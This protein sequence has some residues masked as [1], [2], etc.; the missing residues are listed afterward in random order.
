MQ[1]I[2]AGSSRR[3]K[4]E[5]KGKLQEDIMFDKNNTYSLLFFPFEPLLYRYSSWRYFRAQ[6]A[7]QGTNPSLRIILS[8]RQRAISAFHETIFTTTHPLL[9]HPTAFIAM[10]TLP[11]RLHP[12][13]S[14]IPD[15]YHGYGRNSPLS[16]SSNSNNSNNSRTRARRYRRHRPSRT[17]RQHYCR[18]LHRRRVAV[19]SR[20]PKKDAKRSSHAWF[21]NSLTQNTVTFMTLSLLGKFLSKSLSI[22]HSRHVN[23]N[24]SL[25]HWG[26]SLRSNT[27]GYHSYPL[28]R[29]LTRW[30]AH[31][32]AWWVIARK[33]KKSEGLISLLRPQT[34]SMETVY[35]EYC[36]R[37]EEA[38]SILRHAQE[39]RLAVAEYLEVLYSPKGK[40][41]CLKKESL[42]GKYIA[43]QPWDSGSDNELGFTEPVDQAGTTCLEISS[44]VAS[45]SEKGKREEEVSNVMLKGNAVT[46][47]AWGRWKSGT[48]HS[49]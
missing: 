37:Y 7:W 3:G 14:I 5:L 35:S 24:A 38:L 12:L 11:P 18:D 45:K 31:F 28:A 40:L 21:R 41:E 46:H 43:M 4:G 15:L 6:T 22:I 27:T 13:A 19:S 33:Q 2:Y 32:L 10:L 36:K 29:R 30:H 17:M 47:V 1:R 25:V 34:T 39:S 49:S 48:R 9:L 8:L 44:I 20:M 26:P 23:A 16:R 42:N